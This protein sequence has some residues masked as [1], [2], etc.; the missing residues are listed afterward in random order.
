MNYLLHTVEKVILKTDE[1]LL[2][3]DIDFGETAR[4]TSLNHLVTEVMNDLPEDLKDMCSF[5]ID[6]MPNIFIEHSKLKSLLHM[7]IDQAIEWKDDELLN[8]TFKTN[9]LSDSF[10]SLMISHPTSLID[11]DDLDDLFETDPDN[12]SERDTTTFYWKK[13]WLNLIGGFITAYYDDHKVSYEI[14]LP[15]KA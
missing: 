2:S 9:D 15:K 10:L 14:S 4:D 11:Q 3:N 8:F 12:F 7:I 13:K 1:I 6:D 5:S